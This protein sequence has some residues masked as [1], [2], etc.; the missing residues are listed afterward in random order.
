MRPEPAPPVPAL[1]GQP[2][3]QD[4]V[5]EPDPGVETSYYC[6]RAGGPEG[7]PVGLFRVAKDDAEKV[8]VMERFTLEGEWEDDPELIDELT[9]TDVYEVDEAEA[10]SIQAEI[11]AA[12][13]EPDPDAPPAA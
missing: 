12:S 4:G 6:F 13:P 5:V 10:E 7:R 1:P 9:A 2:A 3:A 8:L 11:L